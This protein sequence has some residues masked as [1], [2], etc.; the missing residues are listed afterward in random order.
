[1]AITEN[2]GTSVGSNGTRFLR[3]GNSVNFVE[4]FNSRFDRPHYYPLAPLHPRR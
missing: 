2:L 4:S 3:K 1:M